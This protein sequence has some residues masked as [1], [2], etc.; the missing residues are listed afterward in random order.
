M[1]KNF[2]NLKTIVL[3]TLAMTAITTWAQTPAWQQQLDRLDKEADQL[4]EKQ[5]WKRLVANQ[6]QYRKIIMAQPDSV[7]QEYLWDTDLSGNFYYNLACWRALAGDKKGALST[8]EYYTDRVINREEI[9]LS[10]I[11]TDSDLNSLRKEPR[12]VKC[13]ERLQKWGD[14]KQI[15]KDAKPYYSGLHPEGIK[16]R[17][18]APNNPDLVQLREQ[19]KLDSVA[20][21]GDEISKIKNLLHWVHEVVPHDGNS[22]NP[23]IK[24]TAAMIELCRKENRGVNCRMMAQM[25]TE[26]YLAM[27]FKA[28]FVTCMP[29]NYVSDCHVITVVYSNTLNKWVWV[30]PTFDL[31]VMDEN[32]TMLSISEVRERIRSDKPLQINDY[33]NWNHRSP[34]TKEYYIDH[35]MA[36]N[37][38]YLVCMEHSRFNAETVIEGQTYRYIALMP[39]D[40][41]NSESSAIGWNDLRIC[42]EQLFWQSPYEE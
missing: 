29:M 22:D 1:K 16:F 21:A 6:E 31:F 18:M 30:D 7:R 24:N 8:F 27:G 40:K 35:Y 9:R 42:D 4:Y 11:N 39:Y 12:F 41:I 25:L 33:A 36:K 14:Y 2:V 34:Q 3:L 20:G 19:F 28:R 13:M 10:H 32:G 37:L 5:D 17:Y 38:Y 26:V 15:L 23:K